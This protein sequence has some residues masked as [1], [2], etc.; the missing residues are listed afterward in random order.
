MS[1]PSLLPQ[2]LDAWS[3]RRA[4]HSRIAERAWTRRAVVAAAPEPE[5]EPPQP[6]PEP[7]P[8]APADAALVECVKTLVLLLCARFPAQERWTRKDL[9]EVSARAFGVAVDDILSERRTENLVHPRQAAAWLCKRFTA[10]S[11]PAIGKAL[12]G[13]DHTTALHAVSKV[14]RVIAAQQ[15]DCGEEPEAWARAIA[16]VPATE[17]RGR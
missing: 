12:G 2:R 4:F 15:I 17:W 6:E 1:A 16:A 10:S 3:R 9:I 11:Y 14:E 8:I 5:P 7:A 13:R